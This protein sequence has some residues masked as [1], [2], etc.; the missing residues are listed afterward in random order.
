MS[1]T[2]GKWTPVREWETLRV[3]DDGL[4]ENEADRLH[5]AAER[6]ARRLKLPKTA[7]LARI[8]RGL[9]AG[10]VVGVLSVPRRTLEILPKI[11]GEDGGVR[12]ALIRM[13]AVAW[14][15]RVADGELTALKTQRSDLLELLIRLFADRLLIAV[16]RGLPRRY[17]SR[18]EDLAQLRGR[19][20][21]KRQFTH[22]AVRPD[23][24][25]CRYDELSEDTPL[26]RVLKA[27]VLRLADRTRSA[28]NGRRLAELTARFEPVRESLGP[29]REPVRLDRTNTAFHDLHRLARLLLSGDWQS[30]TTGRATGFALLFP[31]NLLFEE[32]IGRSLRHVLAPRPVNLQHS[33]LHALTGRGSERLFALRPDVVIGEP[34]ARPIVLDTKWKQLTPRKA[35]CEK[36]MGVAPS[37]VYQMLAYA[38]AYDAKRL[39]LLYPWHQELDGPPGLNRRWAVTGSDCHLDI[40]TVDAGHPNGVGDTLREII[41]LDADARSVDGHL[42]L[43]A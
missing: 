17:L 34:D 10:Q 24:L 23:R 7:V 14:D 12:A 30:T 33:G 20:D 27:A 18:D 31:M 15:V 38:R 3:G 2:P 4:P 28:Q 22:L 35:G 42:P 5:A 39:V 11:D 43:P 32:F 37:D 40:A 21:V 36:T 9:T 29:L 16:R 1:V 6:A 25:A 41:N 13:L 19:L 26:N 8:H